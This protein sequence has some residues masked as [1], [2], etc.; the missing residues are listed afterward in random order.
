MERERSGVRDGMQV[1]TNGRG[2]GRDA[3]TDKIDNKNNGEGRNGRMEESRE[4]TG[5]MRGSNGHFTMGAASSEYLDPR[6]TD[7]ASLHQYFDVANQLGNI[8]HGYMNLMTGV[9]DGIPISNPP[10]MT[11]S[12]PMHGNMMI[13]PPS[14]RMNNMG[15]YPTNHPIHGN[16]GI[17]N[18]SLHSCGMIHTPP[19][20]APAGSPSY[21]S[22]AKAPSNYSDGN[23]S[24]VCRGNQYSWG[25]NTEPKA[26]TG[27]MDHRSYNQT[28]QTRIQYPTPTEFAEPIPYPQ[29]QNID[30]NAQRNAYNY[31][32]YCMHQPNAITND[33]PQSR[34]QGPGSV[35]MT[36]H[37]TMGTFIRAP[38]ISP[39]PGG[40]AGAGMVWHASH[41][42]L[43]PLPPQIPYLG[44]SV[45]M[46]PAVPTAPRY[47]NETPP[48]SRRHMRNGNGQRNAV[49]RSRTSQSVSQIQMDAATTT[50]GPARADFHRQ[51][52]TQGQARMPFEITPAPM[53]ISLLRTPRVISSVP[54]PNSAM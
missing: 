5:I 2:R 10:L 18:H 4:D 14:P 6:P 39:L 23:N 25:A 27:N 16:Q 37:Q 48:A 19:P 40:A 17:D 46:P 30:F 36:D 26:L 44:D 21:Q 41:Y 43:P 49:Q 34:T 20:P 35:S 12:S 52:T 15:E 51:A 24:S 32:G 54:R 47:F 42:D 33:S 53:N 1:E 11:N 8:G 38:T 9:T 45:L 50:E 29:H 13:I 3:V 31:V 7:P 22:P 28:V